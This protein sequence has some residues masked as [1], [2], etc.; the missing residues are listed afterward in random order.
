MFRAVGPFFLSAEIVY[1]SRSIRP[2]HENI[3]PAAAPDINGL[4]AYV[5]LR[6][7]AVVFLVGQAWRHE[8]ITLALVSSA[9]CPVGPPL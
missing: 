9:G 6:A 4:P 8:S 1:M 5:V 2:P 7:F 3:S